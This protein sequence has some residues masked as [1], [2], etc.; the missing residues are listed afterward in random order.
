[1]CNTLNFSAKRPEDWQATQRLCSGVEAFF[2]EVKDDN[3]V[4]TGEWGGYDLDIFKEV[5]RRGGFTYIYNVL[6]K[7]P[8]VTLSRT[9]L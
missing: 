7:G 3:G 5:A 1:M 4:S 2:V 6:Q 8:N 9:S